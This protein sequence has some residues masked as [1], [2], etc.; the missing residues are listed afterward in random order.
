MPSLSDPKTRIALAG[1]WALSLVLRSSP[2][3][4][5]EIKMGLFD[6]GLK[7]PLLR[8]VGVFLIWWMLRANWSPAAA[9]MAVAFQ[10]FELPV[11]M[12]C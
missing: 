10:G 12:S 8:K 3:S 4:S 6:S 9:R 1:I 7:I 11:R 5:N 2:L